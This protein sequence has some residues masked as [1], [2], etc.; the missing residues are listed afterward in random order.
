MSVK[1][2]V[3]SAYRI[4]TLRVHYGQNVYSVHDFIT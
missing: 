4:A 3:A 1:F 2:L